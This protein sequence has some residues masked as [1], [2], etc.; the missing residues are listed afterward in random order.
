MGCLTS[1]ERKAA[2]ALAAIGY[3]NPFLPERVELE[4]QAL[5]RTF[6]PYDLVINR[7]AETEL[8]RIFP[9]MRRMRQRAVELANKMRNFLLSQTSAEQADLTLYE[10]LVL[11]VLYS[12][13]DS[14][15]DGLATQ[16]LREQKLSDP[17]P[18]WQDFL[19]DH[20]FYLRLPNHRFPLQ[21]E[22]AHIFAT[23]FQ[24]QRAFHSIFQN[25]LGRSMAS[26]RL[27]AA[28]WQSIFT[29]DM[30]CYSRTMYKHMADFP[31]L[32]QGPSG[33]GKELVAQA[34]CRS[35]Y[36]EFVPKEEAFQVDRADDFI[37]VNLSALA[38]GLIESELFGHKKGSFAGATSDR[39][40][41]LGASQ[42]TTCVFLDEIGEVDLSIQV[43]LL[44]VLESRT[45]YRVGANELHRFD[46]KLITAT[47]RDLLEEIRAGRFREDFYFRLCADLIHTPSL[48]EHLADSPENLGMLV[49]LLAQDILKGDP[50]E[51]DNLADE[52][53]AWIRANLGDDYEWPGNFRE[54]EQ[55]IRNVMIRGSYTP[56]PLRSKA[57]D[58]ARKLFAEGVA[59]ADLTLAEVIRHYTSLVYARTGSYNDAGERLGIN[60]RTVKTRISPELVEKYQN[61]H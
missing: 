2:K 49:N 17:V 58:P 15:L 8:A 11:Y 51:A 27:R 16:H 4:R 42:P 45:F 57:S 34:I 18:T 29:K 30:Q 59:N 22:P 7:P 25:I 47:N 39:I 33:T 44:R 50:K 12:R 41:F 9:N 32:I 36:I 14:N 21:H 1:R 55:C 26:A 3:C 38:P 43:K 19:K 56:S 61:T 24:I 53:V 10:N 60:W 48:R 35:R 6:I 37:A 23:F 5:G 31:V 54:L 20:D 13:Y 52:V 46:G 28:V 40:G